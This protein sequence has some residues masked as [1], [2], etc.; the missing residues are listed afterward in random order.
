M[1]FLQNVAKFFNGKPLFQGV[2]VSI[3]R[4]DRIG[5]VGPNGAGKSTLLGMM[6]G[7]VTPDEGDVSIEKR[8]R[9]GVLR[10]ELIEG[11]E[12]HILEEVM[13]VS[14]EVRNVREDLARLE[15]ELNNLVEFDERAEALLEEH[16]RLHHLFE[17]FDG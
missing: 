12:G 2:N 16:G 10:Q 8:I 7:V 5:I 6:E 9:L 11:T 15:Q 3:H 14:D 1:I 13:N 4:G 17:A